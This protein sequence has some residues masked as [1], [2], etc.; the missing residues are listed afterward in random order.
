MIRG[1][2][3]QRGE[4]QSVL[5]FGAAWNSP[6]LRRNRFGDRLFRPV[7]PA[8]FEPRSCTPSSAPSCATARSIDTGFVIDSASCGNRHHAVG[9]VGLLTHP[10]RSDVIVLLHSIGFAASLV[11][12]KSNRYRRMYNVFRSDCVVSLA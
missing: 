10:S 2:R 4:F 3:A 11:I 6:R 1:L 7:G 12:G 8:G 9:V 5:S